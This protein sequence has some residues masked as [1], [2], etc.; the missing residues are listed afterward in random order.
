[1]T[2]RR[3]LLAAAAGAGLLPGPAVASP[4]AET[5]RHALSKLLDGNER[6]VQGRPRHRDPADDRRR[7]TAGG[8][9]PFAVIFSCIDS[10]VPPEIVF[11]QDLGDLFV[12]RTAGQVIDPLIAGSIEYGPAH[13]TPLVMVLGHTGCGAV[14]A[15]IESFADGKLPPG[16]IAA[17]VHALAPAYFAARP[18]PSSPLDEQILAVVRAQVTRTVVQLR[19]DP[20]LTNALVVGAVY[21]LRS[22]QVSRIA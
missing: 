22:G 3:T 7:R 15:T 14:K 16:N 10:R 13:G 17:V 12:V 4:P 19:A 9:N 21:D 5:P 11:D 8:Q 1:M 2:A 18:Q 6:W 20:L